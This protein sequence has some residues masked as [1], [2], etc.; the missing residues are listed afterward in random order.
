MTNAAEHRG[1]ETGAH[2]MRI[3]QYASM[4]AGM[5]GTQAEFVDAI[6]HTSPMHDIGKIDTGL[7]PPEAWPPHPG[8]M[9]HDEDHRLEDPSIRND[10]VREDGSRDRPDAP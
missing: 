6:F 9:E 7:H 4:L 1:E 2:V 8:G 3:S 5:L 10:A